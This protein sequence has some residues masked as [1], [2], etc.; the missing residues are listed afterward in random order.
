MLSV[1]LAAPVLSASE[2]FVPVMSSRIGPYADFSSGL[3]G[4]MMD[5]MLMLNRR[6]GGVNGV[7]LIW[8]E[9]ETEYREELGVECYE[10]LK[11]KGPSGAAA[12]NP[13]GTG[14]T[15]A[16]IE[17]AT[18]DKIPIISMGFGRTD[19]SDGRVFPYIFPLITNY[20]SQNTAKIKFIGSREGGMEKLKGKTI[21]N[22]HHGSAYGRETIPILDLQAKKFG[23]EVIHIEVSP[24]G[25]DQ[26]SQWQRIRSLNPDWVILRGLGVMTSAALK[27]A[28]NVGFPPDRMVGVW[29]SGAEEDVIPAGDAAKGFIAAGFHPSGTNFP[30]IKEILKHLYSGGSKGHMEDPGRIGSIYYNRGVIQGILT[31]EAIRV[32]QEK[33][34]KKPL[35]GEQVRW[36]LENLALDE[37][38]LQ[39]L[40]ASNLMQPLKI[41]CFDH[42]GGGAVKFQQWLGTKWNVITDWIASDQTLVRPLIEESA[43]KYAEEKK[44]TPRDCEKASYEEDINRAPA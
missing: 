27:T 32:A 22:L 19:S 33:F 35:T 15:Y 29:W 30:V 38:R 4:G 44:I 39:Q 2:Q 34:G 26:Q 7:K 42:E 37:S 25:T 17:R 31:T 41:S 14:I 21:V 1:G 43:R 3:S 13:F 12:F 23:F 16:L 8:E 24:P 11:N 28:R 36:G 9:C 20:W 18:A 6:D 40:G 10:K 5:Y